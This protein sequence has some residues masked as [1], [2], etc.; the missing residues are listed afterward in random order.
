MKLATYSAADA[1]ANADALPGVVTQDLQAVIPL[2]ADFPDML[3]LSMPEK[4]GLTSQETS[5]RRRGAIPLDKGKAPC[6]NRCQGSS[7]TFIATRTT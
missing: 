7:A 4:K 2:N 1:S 3:S 5:F 6:T